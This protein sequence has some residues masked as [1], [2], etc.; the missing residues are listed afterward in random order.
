M[1]RSEQPAPVYALP[2]LDRWLV[3]A[4]LHGATALVNSAALA[5]LRDRDNGA[6]AGRVAEL[7]DLLA[8]EPQSEPRP[9]QG[10][11]RPQFLGLIPTRACNLRCL[12]CGFG[13][14]QAPCE[15]MDPRMA[16]AAVDWMADEVQREGGQTLDVHFF[17]GEPMAAPD[18]VEVAAH[19]T[20]AA[21]A[22]RGLTP[23]LEAATNGVYS[24]DR[25]RFLGDYFDWVVLSFDGPPDIHDR[26]RPAAGGRGS[27]E[28][29]ARTARILSRSPADFSLR[30]C[31]SQHNVSRLAETARWFCDDFQPATIDI[32][33]LQPTP[34]SEQAG[35]LPPDPYAFA[36]NY[37]RAAR[38]AER[39][40]VRAT[41]S[42]ALTEAPRATFCPV[43]NDALIV[44]PDGR[45]S[46]CYLPEG[47]W[48]ARGLDLNLGR[49][50][51]G[52][53]RLEADCI[54]R[55]RS[56]PAA[57]PRCQQCFCRWSCAGGCVVNHSYPGCPETYDGFCIQTRILTACSLLGASLA[58]DLLG[59][60]AAMEALAFERSDLVETAHG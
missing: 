29:V 21:A 4:P 60:R 42:A 58:D 24:E 26:H 55:A 34:E 38:E 32:E 30:I 53:I 43:G 49:F 9:H 10:P 27:F 17:G 52:A 33:T 36:A 23:R 56:L 48:Q 31:V 44:S 35:L 2:V 54:E 13:A 19:R 40:G 37:W 59:D 28:A 20:R 47:E 12:Y 41:Y 51:D 11:L 1:T 39:Y 50:D 25:A 15:Q 3:H 18:V 6:P 57:Q 7:D 8:R 46:A 5:R 14:A 45:L 22:E 16:V